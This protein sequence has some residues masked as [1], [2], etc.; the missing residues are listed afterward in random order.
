MN[1]K[2]IKRIFRIVFILVSIGSLF[3][4]PWILV[5][6]WIMPLPDSVQ[7]QLKEAVDLGFDGIIVYVDEGA[8]PP[9]FYAEGWKNRENKI[10]ADPHSLF[11]IASIGKLYNAVAIT[12]L[13]SEGRLSL[14]K[15]LADYFP[16]LVGRIENA[17]EITLRMMVQHRS[18]I[19]NYTNTPNFWVDPPESD[20]KKL[21]LVLDLPASFAPGEDYEYSNTNYLLIS[22][23][24]EKVSGTTQFQY[25]K[26]KILE[27]LGLKNTFGSIHDVDMDELMSGYYVGVEEDIKTTDYGSMVATAEDVGIFLRALNDGSLLTEEEQ[28][29]Y[30]SIYKYEHTGLIPGYQS[31]AKY[32]QD[33]DAVVI[34]FNNTTNFDG[35]EWNLAEIVYSRVVRII[36]K[37]S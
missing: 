34:Q 24:I 8:K 15:T 33:I 20:K 28:E 4:V 1:K 31:I 19:P 5:K 7:E 13:V 25:I 10:P 14:D 17:S 22:M 29:I 6:A 16:E 12:K 23:L 26:E 11:K 27:P 21:E 2:Q 9:K 32:H 30:S 37:N 36:R 18:G 35:Y 3:F